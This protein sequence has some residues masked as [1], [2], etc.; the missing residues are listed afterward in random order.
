[1]KYQKH[2]SNIKIDK[3]REFKRRLYDFVLKLIKF[4]DSLPK[5]RVPQRIGDQLIRRGTSILGNY[6]E[7]QSASS[8]RDYTNFFN[9]SLKSA[10]GSKLWIALLRD[11]Q[12][13]K[14]SDANWFLQELDELSKIFAASILT[15]K[16]CR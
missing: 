4:I 6:I 7:S 3:T 10:N 14:M 13:A 15:L 8:K 12:R 1:M 16:G 9:H 2:K 11:S 5:D